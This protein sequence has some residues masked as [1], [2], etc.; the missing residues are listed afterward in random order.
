[1]A[2]IPHGSS[3]TAVFAH[4]TNQ[5][6]SKEREEKGLSRKYA[7]MRLYGQDPQ[8]HTQCRQQQGKKEGKIYKRRRWEL[9]G[10][11][12]QRHTQPFNSREKESKIYKSASEAVWARS[13][14]PHTA[15]ISREK[16]SK[17]R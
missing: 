12:P 13:P 1:M 6:P 17:R 9:Y 3:P 7:P 5:W 15:V 11:D 4:M 16:D 10:L 14:A 8:R 2:L